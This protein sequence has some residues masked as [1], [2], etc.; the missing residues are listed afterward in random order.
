MSANL[1]MDKK[2]PKSNTELLQM[3]SLLS[4]MFVQCVGNYLEL[5]GTYYFLQF[6]LDNRLA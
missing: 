1:A 3:A 2:A 4:L 5:L 6:I